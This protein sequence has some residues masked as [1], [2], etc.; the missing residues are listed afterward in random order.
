MAFKYDAD[1]TLFVKI[2]H[3]EGGHVECY[4]ESDSSSYSRSFDDEDEYEEDSSS[5]KAEESSSS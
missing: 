5:A 2:Y 3:A 4:V 1:M